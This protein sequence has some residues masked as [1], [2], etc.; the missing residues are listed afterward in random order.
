[1]ASRKR[2]VTARHRGKHQVIKPHA[3]VAADSAAT[4]ERCPIRFFMTVHSGST[5]QMKRALQ[6]KRI[7]PCIAG[8]QP[9]GNRIKHDKR[10]NRLSIRPVCLTDWRSVTTFN[11]RCPDAF[12]PALALAA[13]GVICR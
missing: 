6:D 3:A 10:R 4:A 7:T 12:P 13:T 11:D 5:T 9:R 8:R 2:G 1:M